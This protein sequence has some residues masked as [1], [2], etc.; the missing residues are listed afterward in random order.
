MWK[1]LTGPSSEY[2]PDWRERRTRVWRDTSTPL[3]TCVGRPANC[4]QGRMK[5]KML[6]WLYFFNYQ[7]W[8]IPLIF[9]IRNFWRQHILLSDIRLLN[10][11]AVMLMLF[12]LSNSK[13]W[14]SGDGSHLSY[15]SF[16]PA[17]HH[18]SLYCLLTSLTVPVV[19]AVDHAVFVEPLTE[20]RAARTLY[21]IELLRKIREQ[22]CGKGCGCVCQ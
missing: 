7:I 13:I 21:R 17:T 16:S 8:E 18:F 10:P 20:E 15:V 4:L 14:H 9:Q 3:S 1:L 12:C 19:T 5:V 2:W 22:V 11:P 6:V